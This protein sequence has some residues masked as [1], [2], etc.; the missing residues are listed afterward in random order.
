MQD[1][2][3]G[4]HDRIPGHLL[5]LRLAPNGVQKLGLVRGGFRPVSVQRAAPVLDEGGDG[6][7]LQG[8]D[9]NRDESGDHRFAAVGRRTA[10]GHHSRRSVGL[11]GPFHQPRHGLALDAVWNFVESVQH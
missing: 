8:P 3:R 10:G 2:Q 6:L 1:R 5:N 11:C 4:Q 9:L 7:L